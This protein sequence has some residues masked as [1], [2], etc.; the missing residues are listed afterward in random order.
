[1]FCLKKYIDNIQSDKVTCFSY[2]DIGIRIKIQ[3]PKFYFCYIK[4][5]FSECT[6]L[7]FWYTSGLCGNL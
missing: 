5:Y 3:Y 7:R 6:L 4:L 2:T 1:M